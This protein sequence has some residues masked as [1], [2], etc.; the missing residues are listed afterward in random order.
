MTDDISIKPEG[1]T[2]YAGHM[3]FEAVVRIRDLEIRAVRAEANAQA[4]E[5]AL[6]EATSAYRK[7]KAR[8]KAAR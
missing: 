5:R 3:L 8:K 2:L 4:L 6:G 1:V 7:L